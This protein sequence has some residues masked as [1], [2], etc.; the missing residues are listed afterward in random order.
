M[1]VKKIVITD[2]ST[3]EVPCWAIKILTEEPCLGGSIES[4][5]SLTASFY[6]ETKPIIEGLSV[7]K[8]SEEAKQ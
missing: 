2:L 5:E 6:S 7:K 3:D 1:K 8:F 4:K